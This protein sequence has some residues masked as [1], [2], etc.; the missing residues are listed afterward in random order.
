MKRR[1]LPSFLFFL[2]FLPFFLFFF[3]SFFFSFFLFFFFS[4]FFFFFFLLLL[5]CCGTCCWQ[6]SPPHPQ[7]RSRVVHGHR[8]RA[9]F[10]VCG[11]HCWQAHRFRSSLVPASAANLPRRVL[12]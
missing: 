12:R 7:P 6:P 10:H 4:L 8:Q 9:V 1:I 5:L 11:H 2:L 3:F